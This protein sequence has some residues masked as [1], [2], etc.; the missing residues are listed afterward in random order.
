MQKVQCKK[1]YPTI[2]FIIFCTYKH[3]VTYYIYFCCLLPFLNLRNVGRN[4]KEA[5]TY[6]YVQ[7]TM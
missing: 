3:T 1:F 7:L 6:L 2:S 4:T 5:N